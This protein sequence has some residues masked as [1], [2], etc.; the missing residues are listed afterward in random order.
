M[1]GALNT[2]IAVAA[3]SNRLIDWSISVLF[4]D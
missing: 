1:A 3:T 2:R 4:I